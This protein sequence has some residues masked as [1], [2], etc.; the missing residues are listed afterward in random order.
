[1]RKMLIVLSILISLSGCS[2]FKVHK[3]DIE[4]VSRIHTGM[5]QSEVKDILGEPVL[6]NVFDPNRLDYVYTYKPGNGKSVEK[7]ITLIFRN[8]KLT[9]IKGN[10]YSQFI[11]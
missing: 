3:M 7:Y 11:R 10:L 5:T 4:M 9:E 8:G 2:Y 6:S 1:M